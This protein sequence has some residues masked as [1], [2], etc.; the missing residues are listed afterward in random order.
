M[1]VW[2]MW[3]RARNNGSA[4][5][6]TPGALTSKIVRWARAEMASQPFN[7]KNGPLIDLGPNMGPFQECC[8][9]GCVRQICSKPLGISVSGVCVPTTTMITDTTKLKESHLKPG[10]TAFQCD[11]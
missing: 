6:S 3:L 7:L 5:A 2:A 1:E 10:S 8:G 4:C 9:K 11:S